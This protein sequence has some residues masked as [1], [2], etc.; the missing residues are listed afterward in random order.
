MTRNPY[1][2]GFDLLSGQIVE[3][4]VEEA[5]LVYLMTAKNLALY[6]IGRDDYDAEGSMPFAD[7]IELVAGDAGRWFL[8]SE[9]QLRGMY[10]LRRG[11][12]MTEGRLA[13]RRVRD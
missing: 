1:A 3:L 13:M 12:Q 9:H 7:P 10:R 5:G 4:R 11:V 6:C 8:V 2:Q